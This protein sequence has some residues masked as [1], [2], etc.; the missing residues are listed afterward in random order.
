MNI[1]IVVHLNL[2]WHS[3]GL[4]G[5]AALLF[6]SYIHRE[7]QTGLQQPTA[8][9]PVTSPKP[10]SDAASQPLLFSCRHRVP[11]IT[12]PI[13]PAAGIELRM[14]IARLP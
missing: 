7:A 4:D 13:T 8:R 10:A 6:A 1:N 9:Q 3:E 5:S 11:L 14:G 2:G 12:N